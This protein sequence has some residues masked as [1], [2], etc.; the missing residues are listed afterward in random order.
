MLDLW[1]WVENYILWA[2]QL[3][4]PQ[5]HAYSHSSDIW[6]CLL[7]FALKSKAL[8]FL[9]KSQPCFMLAHHQI[10][11]CGLS[12]DPQITFMEVHKSKHPQGTGNRAESLHTGRPLTKWIG[13]RE[14]RT[15]LGS[16]T[17]WPRVLK[18]LREFWASVSSW[19]FLSWRWYQFLLGFLKS[20]TAPVLSLFSP[21]LEFACLNSTIRVPFRL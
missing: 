17:R 18:C 7:M 21:L 2:M 4:K 12:Q 15:D 3:Q 8:L 10:L 9:N 20:R 6:A 13:N 5:D 11:F 1:T 19:G 16:G 14:S